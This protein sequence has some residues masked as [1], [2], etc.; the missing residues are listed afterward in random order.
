MEKSEGIN[1]A[2]KV[3]EEQFPP[4]PN[5][6]TQDRPQPKPGPNNETDRKQQ[7]EVSHLSNQAHNQGIIDEENKLMN[8]NHDPQGY[9]NEPHREKFLGIHWTRRPPASLLPDRKIYVGVADAQVPNNAISTSKY[10]L[11]TFLP[12]NLF[13][14]FSKVANLYFLL[15]AILQ[16]IPDISNTNN[17]P[18]QLLPLGFIIFVSM[19]KDAFEDYKRHKSDFEE[20]NKETLVLK[21]GEFVKVL[22]KDLLI[23][24]IVKVVANIPFY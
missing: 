23:G 19:L 17:Q 10:N 3:L 22:W 24:D 18:L 21:N 7:D 9:E 1:S 5:L 16:V 11:A 8:S 2:I 20:N 12:R 15:I 13:E 6:G 14:Q 4:S